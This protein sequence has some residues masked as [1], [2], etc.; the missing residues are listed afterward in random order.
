MGDKR[1]IFSFFKHPDFGVSVEAFMVEALPDGM[2][3]YNYKRLLN[4]RVGDFNYPFTEAELK[5]IKLVDEVSARALEKHFYVK[6][7]KSGGLAESIKADETLK[8]AVSAYIDRRL[9]GILDLMKGSVVF[10]RAKPGDHPGLEAI[11]VNTEPAQ[12]QYTFYKTGDG[13]R[14]LV[15]VYFQGKALKLLTPGTEIL[16]RQPCWLLHNHQLFTFS[17]GTDGSKIRP[18]LTKPEILIPARMELDYLETFILK[19]SGNEMV[20]Y[21]GFNVLHRPQHLSAQLSL[22]FDLGGKPLLQLHFKY[23]EVDVT[24]AREDKLII[25]LKRTENGP[26]LIR[27]ERDFSFEK[28]ACNVLLEAGLEQI[29][30]SWFRPSE[31]NTEEEDLILWMARYREEL[32]DHGIQV[33]ANIQGETFL[34]E[35]PRLETS[36]QKHDSDWFDIHAFVKIEEFEIPFI[37][38]RSNILNG[39][40]RFRLPDGRLIVLPTEWFTQFRDIFQFADPNQ[41]Q[42]RLQ[43]HHRSLLEGNPLW[44]STDNSGSTARNTSIYTQSEDEKFP[45]PRGLKAKLRDYQYKGFNWLCNLRSRNYSACLADDMGLGKTLQVISLLQYIRENVT[46]PLTRL[47]G[48]TP[49]LFSAIEE[50]ENHSTS[51]VVMSPSL[52]Y[53]WHNE[54]RK[55]APGLKVL[56][57]TGA[58]RTRRLVR[59]YRADVVLTSYGVVR[60]DIELLRQA[61][62]ECIVLDESQ[63]IKN[64][65][66][67]NFQSVRQLQGK[68][69]IILTGTPVENSL[70]DL[71]SQFSFLHPGLLGSMQFFRDEYVLPVEQ[72]NDAS[73]LEKLRKLVRPFFLRRTKEEV[74]PELPGLS[75]NVHYCEMNAAQAELYEKE[76]SAFRNLILSKVSESGIGRNQILI[77]KG[78]MRLRLLAIHPLLGEAAYNGSSGK[79]SEVLTQLEQLRA[80]GRKVL[81]FSQFVK[82]L[83]LFRTHFEKEGIEY[84]Y[85]SGE[86][87]QP[88]RE[89]VVSKF[90]KHSCFRPFL[91][92]LKTG[93]AGL[94]LT[95]ADSVFLL[96]PWWNPAVEEQAIA[97]SHRMGQEK[98]VF[99]WRFITAG[100]I[101]EKILSLQERKARLAG[102][103]VSGSNPF[104]KITESELAELFG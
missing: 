89:S 73:K 83:N 82:H 65:R 98:P 100:S 96:D 85:L 5:A 77:L 46:Q 53:N 104:Q 69:R 19:A 15:Q 84:S 13:I 97:R 95:S 32:A 102:D 37:R 18:F 68:Q 36:I 47:S 103:I 88:E 39:N 43:E 80:E 20:E 35:A 87:P 59:L 52:L 61:N 49:D 81:M 79:F 76:K 40:R 9:S 90:E 48:G 14:Y 94:N 41:E 62:F 54:I 11:R 25:K 70:L 16:S 64:P 8:K 58:R 3:S 99:V 57:H 28:A 24:A 29:R 31:G 1:L 72:K 78:L 55:F 10:L 71:W 38:F 93:G 7:P 75:L 74:A 63:N 86:V 42:L 4:E 27:Y 91:I 50:E 12:V 60:N 17:D 56:V 92:Q 34:V 23:D 101:E 30:P 33:K 21:H 26:V 66:S 67:V 45:V 2:F 6:K 51:L 22:D 44:N